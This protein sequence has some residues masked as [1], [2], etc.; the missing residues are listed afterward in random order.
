MLGQ[1]RGKGSIGRVR[2]LE[3]KYA[4]SLDNRVVKHK[5]ISDAWLF[6]LSGYLLSQSPSVESAD[7]SA[8]IKGERF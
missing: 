6:P 3:P 4:V 8:P 2:F 7:G 5:G 1:S